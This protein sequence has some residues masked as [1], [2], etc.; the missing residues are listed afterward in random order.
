MPRAKYP[1]LRPILKQFASEHGL[2]YLESGEFEILEMN[3]ELYKEVA[4][5][6]PVVGAPTMTFSSLEEKVSADLQSA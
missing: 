1:E 2:T 3:W 4:K 5:A 6:D